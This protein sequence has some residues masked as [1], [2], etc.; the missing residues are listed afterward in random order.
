[1]QKLLWVTIILLFGCGAN[2][3]FEATAR[4]KLYSVGSFQK[5]VDDFKWQASKTGNSIV[6]DD[7][8]IRFRHIPEEI[9]LAQC[10]L[11]TKDYYPPIID[12]DPDKWNNLSK[13]E[14]RILIFHEL[15]HCILKRKHIDHYQSIMNT[16][17]LDEKKFT[18]DKKLFMDELFNPEK[19]PSAPKVN[20]APLGKGIHKCSH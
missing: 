18:K 12:V 20:L 17:L 11:F 1:M 2:D 8:V 13:T 16:Y 4:D 5:Y 3:Q 14:K 15:G 19:Y 6:I 9:I 7:L 10:L